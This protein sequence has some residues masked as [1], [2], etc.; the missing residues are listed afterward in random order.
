MT[1]LGTVNAQVKDPERIVYANIGGPETMDPHWSYD[2]ASVRLSSGYDNLMPMTGEYRKF[3]PML[4]YK[5]L[6]KKWFD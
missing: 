1:G 2:T 6:R 3:V 4:H 5:F